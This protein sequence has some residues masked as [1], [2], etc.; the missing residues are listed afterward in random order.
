MLFDNFANIIER[1]TISQTWR[2]CNQ[3]CVD[4]SIKLK[5]ICTTSSLHKSQE[6]N[7]FKIEREMCFH[8]L[9]NIL[10]Y[11]KH[12]KYRQIH[13]QALY[14]YLSKKYHTLD[15]EFE[16]VLINMEELLEFIGFKKGNDDNWYCQYHIQLLHLWKHYQEM[17]ILQPMYFICVYFVVVNKTMI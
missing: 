7:E 14:N 6:E 5:E 4:T 12:I 17:S 1:T 3:I 10:K 11:P 16:I 8:I 13:K 9:W 2:N 15:A